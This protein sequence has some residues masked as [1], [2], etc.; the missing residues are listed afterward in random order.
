M[1]QISYKANLDKFL[2]SLTPEQMV[3]LGTLIERDIAANDFVQ[4]D[5]LATLMYERVKAFDVQELHERT[6][7]Q[8]SDIV[9]T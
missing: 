3:F 4:L 1:S 7:R 5:L 2:D 9:I 8:F 6:H